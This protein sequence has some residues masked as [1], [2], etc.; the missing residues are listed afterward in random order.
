[1]VIVGFWRSVVLLRILRQISATIR[2][3]PVRRVV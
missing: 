1:M 3:L 2:W